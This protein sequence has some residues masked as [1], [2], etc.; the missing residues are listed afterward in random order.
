MTFAIAEVASHGGLDPSVSVLP[1]DGV[2]QAFQRGESH[3]EGSEVPEERL[4]GGLVHGE[5]FVECFIRDG[6]S[7]DGAPVYPGFGKFGSSGRGRAE[8]CHD[9]G[10]GSAFSLDS[11]LHFVGVFF[12]GGSPVAVQSV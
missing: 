4:H 12:E 2:D 7:D 10:E 6:P 9:L 8:W 11:G 5:N 3:S 1:D